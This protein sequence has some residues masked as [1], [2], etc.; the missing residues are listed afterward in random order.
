MMRLILPLANALPCLPLSP[1][2]LIAHAFAQHE[3][4]VLL[5]SSVSGLSR[6]VLVF[7]Q[8]LNEKPGLLEGKGAY[9][10]PNPFDK[11]TCENTCGV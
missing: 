9:A 2:P 1:P 11:G 6:L 4:Y 5:N 3:P 10:P 8:M 7:P